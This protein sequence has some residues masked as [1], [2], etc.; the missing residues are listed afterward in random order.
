MNHVI[1]FKYQPVCLKV[2]TAWCTLNHAFRSFLA[3][4]GDIVSVHTVK[5]YRGSWG[6]SPPILNLEVSITPPPYT[7]D[8]ERVLSTRWIEAG[9]NP[10][11]VWAFWRIAKPVA[12]VTIRNPDRP[13]RSQK[14]NNK[15]ATT[16]TPDDEVWSSQLW[17]VISFD[18]H[19][20]TLRPGINWWSC[21]E[22][23]DQDIQHRM[24]QE[25]TSERWVG[26]DLA[27]VRVVPL[28]DRRVRLHS[29]INSTR[30]LLLLLLLLL[31]CC[32]SGRNLVLSLNLIQTCHGGQL[33]DLTT[34][35]YR[36]L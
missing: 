24:R 7:P 12:S 20:D 15:R 34:L 36:Y 4:N 18:V 23:S 19:S 2:K 31:Y 17:H 9:R 6:T 3:V 35:G 30:L 29:H 14:F 22:G 16:P 25:D 11:A 27:V 1:K 21:I 26:D 5:A 13:T 10:Q 32:C 33:F 8:T 28:L